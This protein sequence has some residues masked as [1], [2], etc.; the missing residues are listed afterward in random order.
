MQLIA[1]TSSAS[2]WYAVTLVLA[3]LLVGIL[4]AGTSLAQE[5]VQRIAV[6]Y[7]AEKGSYGRI[8]DQIVA[9]IKAAADQDVGIEEYAMEQD[10]VE[11]DAW[12]QTSSPGAIITLGRRSYQAVAQAGPDVPVVAGAVVL[13]PDDHSG[14]SLAVDP[15]LFL[16]TLAQLAPE[17]RHV[18]V[19]YNPRNSGWLV[20]LG[21]RA[22]ADSGV[23]IHPYPAQDA[24]EAARQYKNLLNAMENGH[25]AIWLPLDSVIP[26]NTI[27]PLVLEEAWKRNLVI[28]S[29]NPIHV[30]RGALFA[31]YPDNFDTGRRL[32][33]MA[34]A[35]MK[36]DQRPRVVPTRDA[37]IAVNA[38]TAAHLGVENR[39]DRLPDID[40]LYPA[41][42]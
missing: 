2:R 37:R 32:Y 39:L 7:P 21:R 16:S 40:L 27:L 23:T 6:V 35:E 11:I 34:R 26:S 41:G 30:R 42:M 25:S 9:G 20:E 3:F 33:R 1:G 12:L 28:F 5:P 10:T 29:N 4:G 36:P 14:I 19:V 24:K 38:R 18:Y 15:A 13:S 17:V 22:A 8:Y 31:L